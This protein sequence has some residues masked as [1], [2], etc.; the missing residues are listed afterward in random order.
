MIPNRARR[1]GP[2][3]V[4]YWFGFTADLDTTAERGILLREGF[5][6]D[7][8]LYDPSRVVGRPED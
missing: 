5:P 2:G 3:L 7:V 8:E 4:I 1:F 6:E